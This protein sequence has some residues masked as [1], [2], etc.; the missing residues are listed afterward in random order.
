MSNT[1]IALQL[2][3]RNKIGSKMLECKEELKN[4]GIE[5]PNASFSVD[6]MNKVKLNPKDKFIKLFTNNIN[7]IDLSIMEKGILT[8]LTK[9]LN[10][11]DT[12]LSYEGA[13]I[14]KRDFYTLLDLG[15]NA[16]DKYISQLIKKNVLFKCKCGRNTMYHM[17]PNIYYKGI[18]IDNSLLNIFTNNQ[19]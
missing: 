14:K 12:L 5:M 2:Y 6:S 17:N 10:Y 8:E 13:P 7:L 1:D 18:Y 15:K 11:E 4:E 16:I 9:Y 3:I 19:I